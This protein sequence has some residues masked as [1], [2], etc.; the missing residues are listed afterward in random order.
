G[1][2]APCN[3]TRCSSSASSSIR[4]MR[5]YR[6]SARWDSRLSTTPKRSCRP[7]RAGACAPAMR[8]GARDSSRTSSAAKTGSSRKHRTTTRSPR[9]PSSFGRTC[10]AAR[11]AST[12]S[13]LGFRTIRRSTSD[14]RVVVSD[15]AVELIEERGNRVY[16]WLN[17]ARCCG[18]VTM[19]G[20]ASEPPRRKTFV[21]VEA[22]EKFELYFD[23]RIPRFPDELHLDL[24]RFPRRVEAYWNGCA[25]VI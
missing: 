20:T 13:S 25:W 9:A 11:A 4:T 7:Q 24:R 22:D 5:Q 3:R 14:V 10:C 16:V 15:P 12:S 17:K 19:L 6:S 18:G 8:A 23:E 1:S 21:R 2:A